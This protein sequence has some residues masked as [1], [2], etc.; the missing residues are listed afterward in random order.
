VW[1]GVTVAAAAFSLAVV[2]PTPILVASE[3]GM[4][5]QTRVVGNGEDYWPSV[6]RA[7]TSAETGV[8]KFGGQTPRSSSTPEPSEVR[9]DRDRRMAS[10]AVSAV[11]DLGEWLQLT[12]SQVAQLGKVSRR[13]LSN[14]RNTGGAYGAS[15]RHLLSVHALVAQLIASQGIEKTRLWLAMG[16]DTGIDRLELLSQGPEGLRQ[17]LGLADP[18][19]FP[20]KATASRLVDDDDLEAYGEAD[21]QEPVAVNS[22]AASFAAPPRRPRSIST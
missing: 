1:N 13:T 7:R 12:D 18:L 10:A 5:N 9:A 17:V 6:I 15:S 4:P 2:Q 14:W 22:T 8:A 20:A 11:D 3:L 16:T 19:I 21:L